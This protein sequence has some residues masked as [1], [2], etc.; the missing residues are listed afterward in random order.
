MC[1]YPRRLPEESCLDPPWGSDNY[2]NRTKGMGRCRVKPIKLMISLFFRVLWCP[3]RPS[4]GLF[5]L[6]SVD[7]WINRPRWYPKYESYLEIEPKAVDSRYRREGDAC[8]FS[9]RS[10]GLRSSWSRPGDFFSPPTSYFSSRNCMI[11][12]VFSCF[13]GRFCCGLTRGETMIHYTFKMFSGDG[14]DLFICYMW[15]VWFDAH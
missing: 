9:D 3:S 2:S 12:L 5:Y 15:L 1:S 14:F 4:I 13:H 6:S 11:L 10:V 7:D 8:C